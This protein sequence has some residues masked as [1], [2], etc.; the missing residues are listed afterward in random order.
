MQKVFLV[1]GANKGIGKEICHQLAK[2]CP[3]STIILTSR[4]IENGTKTLKE[5]ENFKNIEFHQ[6]DVEDKES[7]K[8]LSKFISEKYS[9]ID[10]LINNAGFM[11]MATLD[12]EIAKKTLGINY[13]GL[14]NVTLEILPLLNKNG[15]VVNIS[16]GLGE[17]GNFYSEEIKE[18]IFNEDK[19]IE[20]IDELC[21]I[22]LKSVKEDKIKENGWRNSAYSV[23]K[24]MVNKLTRVLK[25]LY[26]S[27][28]RN[29]I[30]N[31]CCPGWV[32]TDMGGPN[33]MRNV[34]QGS[35]TPVW[36]SI[37]ENLNENGKFFRDKKLI[38]F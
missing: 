31:A 21:E 27:D 7:I 3:K 25:N 23:S 32:K 17:I 5:F 9:K 34:Q 16:S 29:L 4:S 8:Q 26:F 22:F 10:V 24:A 20:E 2:S 6:L 38:S 13:F 35:E 28:E 1:T 36:L 12:E 11:S 30:F 33:A 14:K 19:S 15:R 37:E 18:K